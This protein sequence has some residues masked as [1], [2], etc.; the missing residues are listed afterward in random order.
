MADQNT[1]RRVVLSEPDGYNDT[2]IRL[3]AA[4]GLPT[5]AWIEV[6]GASVTSYFYDKASA[7]TVAKAIGGKA[8]SAGNARGEKWWSWNWTAPLDQAE[9]RDG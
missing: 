9:E 3:L 1:F 7:K 2:L 4:E 8:V 5:P 6:R